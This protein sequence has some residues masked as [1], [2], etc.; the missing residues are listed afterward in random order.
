MKFYSAVAALIAADLSL[1]AP[2][3][4]DL[5]QSLGISLGV[6]KSNNPYTPDYR[7]PYDH[8][9]DSWGKGLHPLPYRNGDGATVQ[10]PRNRDRERE[11][12]DLVRPP[13]TDRG[14][15]ANMRWSYAD[16][17]IRIEVCQTLVRSRDIMLNRH[18]RKVDGHVKPHSVKLALASR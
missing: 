1:A 9:V 12:P 17:H 16:S 13:S 10:G 11:N 8:K 5:Q 2:V 15:V 7:D 3:G 14:D 4:D 18:I 6:G